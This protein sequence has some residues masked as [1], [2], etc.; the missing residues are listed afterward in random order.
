M[1]QN[2]FIFQIG[3]NI[4]TIWN[5]N[6]DH[7]FSTETVASYDYCFFLSFSEDVEVSQDECSL[8][9]ASGFLQKRGT[10]RVSMETSI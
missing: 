8:K 5:Y 6:P 7:V 2:G 10:G 3:V 9:N 1:R 4:K